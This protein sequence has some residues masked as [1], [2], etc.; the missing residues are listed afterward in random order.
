MKK[1]IYILLFV[2]I[3]IVTSC[4]LHSPSSDMTTGLVDT[5]LQD[6]PV[7]NDFFNSIIDSCE[8]YW[9]EDSIVTTITFIP[10]TDGNLNVIIGYSYKLPYV[11]QEFKDFAIQSGFTDAE[12][13]KTIN[14]FWGY[15][16]ILN[17]GRT[18]FVFVNG[19]NKDD[20]PHSLLNVDKLQDI[21]L[22]YYP[23][24]NTVY[25]GGGHAKQ[26]KITHCDKDSVLSRSTPAHDVLFQK[27]LPDMVFD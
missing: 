6:N 21:H 2:L 10:D 20:V 27:V 24:R 15:W 11:S 4:R 16:T 9:Q 19:E 22:L 8:L 17:N 18:N 25:Y 3:A 5:C 1:D 13:Y 14:D 26:Y 7:T 12:N 23:D